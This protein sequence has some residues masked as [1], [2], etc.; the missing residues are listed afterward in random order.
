MKEV[1]GQCLQDNADI[2]AGLNQTETA[3]RNL[4]NLRKKYVTQIITQ[5]KARLPQTLMIVFSE[6]LLSLFSFTST[7]N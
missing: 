6:T 5:I 4:H 1:D 2:F 7:K 3:K